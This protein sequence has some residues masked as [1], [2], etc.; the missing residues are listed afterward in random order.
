MIPKI[1]EG[2]TINLKKEVINKSF[3]WLETIDFEVEYMYSDDDGYTFFDN[4]KF[5]SDLRKTMVE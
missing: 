1:K 2:L 3:E 4:E 5:I